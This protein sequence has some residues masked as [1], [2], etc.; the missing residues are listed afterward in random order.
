[1]LHRPAPA[2]VKSHVSTANHGHRLAPVPQ[3][4]QPGAELRL[5]LVVLGARS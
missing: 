1:M 4:F 5:R 2:Q 3:I